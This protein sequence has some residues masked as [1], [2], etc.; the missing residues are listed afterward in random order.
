MIWHKLSVLWAMFPHAQRHQAADLAR[1]WD[2]ALAKDPELRDD[3]IRLGGV[4]LIQPSMIRDGVAEVAPIDPLAQA[5]A[6]GRRDFALQLLALSGLS[7]R[8]MNTLMKD[9]DDV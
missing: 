7:I 2:R 8:D 9:D 6:A 5:Y 4:C 3:L 1:R